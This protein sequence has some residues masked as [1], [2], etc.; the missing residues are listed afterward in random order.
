M[1][2]GEERYREAFVRIEE[3]VRAALSGNGSEEGDVEDGGWDPDDGHDH[4]REQYQAHVCT[5]KSVP[6]HLLVEAARKAVEINPVNAPL[7]GPVDAVARNFF[8]DPLR[9]AAVTAKYWGPEPRRLTVSF[10]EAAPADL[11]ARIVEHLNGWSRRSGVRFV[12]T[13]GTGQVRITREG[14]GYWSYL[15]TDILLR[16]AHLPTMSLRGFTMRTSEREFRRVVRHEA[17]HTLG[18]PHEHMRRELV[19]RIDPARAYEYF[20]RT[21]GWDRRMVDAQVLTPLDERTIMSTPADQT[22]IMCYQLPGTITRDGRPILGGEDINETDHAFAAR[23][24]P[25]PRRARHPAEGNGTPYAASAAV[26]AAAP[27][28][29]WDQAFELA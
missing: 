28:D 24:Y 25:Q 16:P 4:D 26:P 18:F 13:R 6:R 7:M 20:R 9:I 5:P 14:D 27:A 21:Q 17:G 1:T 3:V 22:S 11:R 12:E 15:G 29:D 19:E 2:D 8:S 10:M 23:I